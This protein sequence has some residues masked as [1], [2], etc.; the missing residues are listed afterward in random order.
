MPPTR[1]IL[2]RTHQHT[3]QSSRSTGYYTRWNQS[4]QGHRKKNTKSDISFEEKTIVLRYNGF[5]RK[6]GV[7]GEI[8]S[9]KAKIAP[10]DG[11]VVI[12]LGK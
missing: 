4:P 8:N 3:L 11:K 10:I 5:E 1:Q 6:L 7:I 9:L 12:F 2:R